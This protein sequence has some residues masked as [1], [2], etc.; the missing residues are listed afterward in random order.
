MGEAG[1]GFG[2]AALTSTPSE[3]KVGE[4]DEEVSRGKD[5]KPRKPRT[6]RP[7]VR[8][9]TPSAV[10]R[11]VKMGQIGVTCCIDH[12]GPEGPECFSESSVIYLNRDHPLYKRESTDRQRHMM[13]VGRLIT[14]ELAMMKGSDC[15]RDA[16]ERQSL[17]LRDAFAS[18]EEGPAGKGKKK[19][20]RPAISRKGRADQ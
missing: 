8:K 12:Y 6:E 13:H 15:A 1:E 18:E 5:K 11:K 7:H 10:V 20:G 19:S 4:G 16:F 14:Q 9:L 17:L 3:K 2:D